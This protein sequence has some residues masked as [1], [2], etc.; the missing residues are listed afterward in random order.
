MLHGGRASAKTATVI[1][2]LLLEAMREKQLILCTRE[3]QS[4][5]ETSTY[6][7]LRDFIYDNNLQNQFTVKF[8]KIIHKNGSEIIFKG[9][10]R[11]IMSIKSIAKIKICFVEEAETIKDKDWI[12][13]IPTIMR[14]Q[15]AKIIIAFNPR[16]INSAT[17]QRFITNF[18]DLPKPS[19]NININYNDNPFLSKTMY[20]EISIM[21]KKNY[22]L[23]EHIYLGKL[24]DISE[25][26]IFKDCFEI[27]TFEIDRWYHK[28]KYGIDFGFS[29]DPFA[30]VELYVI[31]EN[32]IYIDK[33]IYKTHLLTKDI[34]TQIGKVMPEA[35]KTLIYADSA[36]PD[37]IAELKARGLNIRPAK[38]NQGS[39]KSGIQFLQSKKII[40]NPNC[41]DMIVE[42]YNYKFKKDKDGNILPDPVDSF[43]HLIDAI[44]YAFSEEI[45]KLKTFDWQG[46]YKK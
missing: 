19:L 15:D 42:L 14:N 41:T 27:R 31:D 2:Y 35:F 32:T 45:A 13:L 25:E 29:Q 1:R 4:S 22:G 12:V 37:T 6:A 8:D 21:R 17:Y 23:F 3:Y 9:L 11:D 16:D 10:A 38:K 44:R 30:M 7:E 28:I 40:V 43:N 36:R 26:V 24:L 46:L 34:L 5:I 20:D 18:N 39:I 33:T